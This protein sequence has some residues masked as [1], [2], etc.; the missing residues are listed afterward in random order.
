MQ[1]GETA[2]DDLG[3]GSD[4]SLFAGKRILLTGHTGFKGSWLSL[5][6]TDLG[7]EVTGYALA[8]VGDHSMYRRLELDLRLRSILG[9][10]RDADRLAKVV[11]EC[12]PEIVFHLAAQP[13]VSSSYH[14][15]K[16][17]FDINIQ[18]TVNLLEAVRK[19]RYMKSLVCVTTDK[20]YRNK[21]WTWGYRE[22]D[23][24]G[25]ED[26]YSASKAAAE[27]VVESYS[28]SFFGPKGDIGVATARA[29]N[30]IGGG[31]WS[32]NRLIPDS[33]RSVEKNKPIE[34][35]NPAHVRPWQ[36]VL[37]PLY[38][39]LKLAAALYDEPAKFSGSWNFGPTVHSLKTVEEVALRFIQLW[40]HGEIQISA[41]P[42]G[43]NEAR[44]L[45]LNSEKAYRAL[46]W[47]PT[48]NLDRALEATVEWY[49]ASSES[50]DMREVTRRQI[51][52]FSQCTKR[53]DQSSPKPWRPETPARYSN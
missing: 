35:R 25:G 48:W 45:H 30:V 10:V 4:L 26:P 36:H 50:R 11:E 15:P 9:D 18:G 23:E 2:V 31:D 34:I 38:G 41:D 19:V 53:R 24:L 47:E 7:A 5:W 49:Q 14:D 33:V 1:L 44:T 22:N 17:T 52:D 43:F 32:P 8:P 16:A 28:R 6:L 20:C 3:L 39:Y 40:G 13:I 37:D 29:G 27:I 46:N 51:A 12:Q 21:A 42:P